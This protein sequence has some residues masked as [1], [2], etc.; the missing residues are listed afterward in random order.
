MT[1]KVLQLPILPIRDTVYF[2][3]L[4]FPISVGRPKSIGAVE[5]ALQSDKYMAIFAQR[6]SSKNDPGEY[7]LYEIGTM[8]KIIKNVKIPG[9]KLSVVLQGVSR[10]RMQKFYSESNALFADVELIEEEEEEEEIEDKLEE[11]RKI[12]RQVFDV[13]PQIQAEATFLVGST[14]D[15]SKVADIIAVNMH[16]VDKDEKQELLATIDVSQRIDK[17]L[18]LLRK[19]MQVLELSN[20]IQS[21]VKGEM[22]KAQREY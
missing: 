12:A 4:A 17:L 11:L 2:P 13:S 15:P 6:E 8:V 7:D 5:E 3:V 1:G 18:A 20:K 9:N 21:S 19:E 22:D 16:N 14:N 10:I